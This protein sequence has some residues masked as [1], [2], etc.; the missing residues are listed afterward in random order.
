MVKMW[1]KWETFCFV[2]VYYYIVAVVALLA[3]DTYYT[4]LY[5]PILSYGYYSVSL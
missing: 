2:G 5:S 1:M 3:S 4:V